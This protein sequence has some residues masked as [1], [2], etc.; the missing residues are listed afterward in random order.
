MPPLEK[1][2]LSSGM[3]S[4]E[5]LRFPGGHKAVG[6]VP[7]IPSTLLSFLVSISIHLTAIQAHPQMSLG[8]G[9]GPPVSKAVWATPVLVLLFI[10]GE[11]EAQ[12]KSALPS[13]P[14]G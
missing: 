2:L 6:C 1:M 11:T 10:N 7:I 12:R 8:L 14:R 5:V 9:Q 13:M 3:G 4:W